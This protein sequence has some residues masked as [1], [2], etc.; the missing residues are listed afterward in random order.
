MCVIF[1]NIHQKL[2]LNEFPSVCEPHTTTGTNNQPH[3]ELFF[4]SNKHTE[5][6]RERKREK[7]LENSAFL[8][9]N[10]VH[11]KIE[12]QSREFYRKGKKYGGKALEDTHHSIHI[13]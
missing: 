7:T 3:V 12:N 11:S 2:F 13:K 10:V 8:N 1:G 5:W 9:I 6:K 4:L